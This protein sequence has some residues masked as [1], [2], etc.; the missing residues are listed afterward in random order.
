MSDSINESLTLYFLLI[1]HSRIVSPPCPT[2]DA[3]ATL[4]RVSPA[5]IDLVVGELLLIEVSASGGYASITWQRNGM[6]LA[7]TF[8][9]HNE[10]Y[11]KTTTD[12][13]DRGEYSIAVGGSPTITVTVLPYG[14]TLFYVSIK[15]GMNEEALKCHRVCHYI[16]Y[17]SHT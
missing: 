11:Y 15:A 5:I 6:V 14:K 16:S 8:V 13:N 10:V 2:A 17:K 7:D 12:D 9:S 1:L 3:A 4:T